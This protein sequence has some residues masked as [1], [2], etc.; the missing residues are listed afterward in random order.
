MTD[1]VPPG[2]A[3]NE[4][5]SFVL[6][7]HA[8]NGAGE[9]AGQLRTRLVELVDAVGRELRAEGVS[10][11][12]QDAARFAL[13]A[14]ADEMLL[15]SDWPGRDAWQTEPLQ[16]GLLNT[17]KAG[18]E[19]FERLEKL[20]PRDSTARHVFLRA[21][22]LGFEGGHAGRESDRVAIIR[23]QYDLLR[24]AGSALPLDQVAPL[25]DG[26]YDLDISLRRRSG[27]RLGT[28]IFRWIMV[29]ALAFGLL[30]TVARFILTGRVPVP[31]V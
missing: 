22:S 12:E 4:F 3:A 27:A 30:W 5:F 13:V 29:S 1:W 9:E 8:A 10:D 17:R 2:R 11:A 6:A 23:K 15:K 16:F 14:F 25:A 18:D 20:S 21:L 28:T 26:A 24:T 19:F 7:L 31:P